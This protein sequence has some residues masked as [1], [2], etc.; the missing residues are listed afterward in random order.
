LPK[1]AAWTIPADAVSIANGVVRAL[2]E[3]AGPLER[4]AVTA[5]A[6]SARTPLKIDL[7][8]ETVVEHARLLLAGFA[9]VLAP[10][11]GERARDETQETGF[12]ERLL[13]GLSR[14]PRTPARIAVLDAA[15]VVLADHE[16]ATSTLAARVAAS[17]RADPFAVV[18]AGLGAVSGPLHGK[19]AV[20]AHRMIARAV[21]GAAPEAAVAEA[22]AASRH[23]PGFRHPV[24]ERVDPRA[25]HLL[26]LLPSVVTGETL[27]RIQALIAAGR[28]S[29]SGYENVDFGLGAVALALDME[30]GA[31][32]AIFAVARTA[33][34]IAHAMEE[35]GE[36][37]LRFR[38]R[39]IYDGELAADAR[40]P[41][42][43][44]AG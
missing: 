23:V 1:H 43:R 35:Y 31:T 19:A 27:A 8:P 15:L 17:T 34:W 5:G 13:S 39:S 9:E 26:A 21:S 12:A 32:E 18:L 33:G 3:G 22:L 37:P 25:A 24:Y 30:V 38:A 36:T 10:R 41:G 2:P 16:L 28:R 4:L 11:S 29:A 7:R 40:A 20:H 6:L 14:L 42:A 44:E